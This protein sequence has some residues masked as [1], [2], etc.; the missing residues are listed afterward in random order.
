MQLA[1]HQSRQPERVQGAS[2]VLS[3]S[4]WSPG[5]ETSSLTATF[6]G[7]CRSGCVPKPRRQ[8][9]RELFLGDSLSGFLGKVGIPKG[10][11]P[12]T[13]L[14]DQMDR[15]FNAY[16]SLIYEDRRDKV[17]MNA[18][19]ADLTEF[20]WNERKPRGADAM[21]EQDRAEREVL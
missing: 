13:R 18:Q 21:A 4:T 12:R 7:C 11:G 14:R 6:P 5:P 8:Q 15:L 1:P 2:T 20:W 9:S 16:V 17:T 19:I 3:L 10:G